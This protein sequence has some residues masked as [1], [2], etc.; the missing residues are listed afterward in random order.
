LNEENDGSMG[1]SGWPIRAR[2]PLV[3]EKFD[4]NAF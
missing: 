1:S 2:D 3:A 4:A